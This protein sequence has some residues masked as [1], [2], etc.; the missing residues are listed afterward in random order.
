MKKIII[1]SILFLAFAS[2]SLYAQI[3]AGY[4]DGTTGLTGEELKSKLHTIIRAH[5][6]KS[7]AEVKDVLRD[8]DEDP[9]NSSNVLLIY[10]RRSI[11]KND[12]ASN[13]EPDFWNREHTWP[14][15]HGFPNEQDTA[16][17]DVHHLRPCDATIN[18]SRSNKDFNNVEHITENEQGEAAN[19]YTT[20]NF[21]EPTDEVKGDMARTMFYMATRY[22]STSLNLELVDRISFS[23]DPELGVLYTLLQWH[24]NDPVSQEEIDRNDGAYGYQGNRNP[25]IDDPTW[26]NAI[27]GNSTDPYLSLNQVAFSTDF[28]TVAA[29]NNLTQQYVVKGYNL[30]DDIS[31]TVTSPFELSLDNT[32]WNQSLVIAKGS[33]SPVETTVYLRFSPT[34]EDGMSYEATVSHSA[35]GTNVIDFVVTGIEGTTPIM[36]IA[37]AR[38]KPLNDVVYVTGVVISKGN[39]SSN[40]RVIFDGTAG[41]VVRSFDAN[42]ESA[43]LNYGDSITVSGGLSEYNNLL[44]IENSPIVLTLIKENATVPDPQIVTVD[45]IDESYESELVKVENVEFVESGVFAGGGSAGNFTIKDADNNRVVLR[46]GSSSHPLVGTEIPTGKVT[47]T[48]FIGQFGS[49]YQVNPRDVEDIIVIDDG[50]G[51]EPIT[52]LDKSSNKYSI[53]PNPTNNAIYVKGL[54]NSLN[55]FNVSITSLNGNKIKKGFQIN[56]EYIEVS[57][58][59]QGIYLLHLESQNEN[60]TLKIIKR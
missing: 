45:V 20:D 48:G 25:F 17:T 56:P 54:S 52:G 16:Y 15:S 33:T 26:I 19:T 13:N 57:G 32:D 1:A 49:D 12:F 21:W 23:G 14:K 11:S 34:T 39:N 35:S 4:Y 8:I 44:Q 41:I 27:W 30:T 59:A 51:N 31:V 40:S 7:Y 46:I 55:S 43:P 6:V 60:F 58:L 47:I 3:P 50:G 38:S 2:N 5:T 36:N 22:N 53:Y 29:G 24:E 18:S 37:D 28:G 42:N 10:S 9:N